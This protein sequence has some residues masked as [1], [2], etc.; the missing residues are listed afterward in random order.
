MAA[1]GKLEVKQI[2]SPIRRQK[3]QAEC[4]KGLG[5]GK[6]NRSRVLEDTPSIRGL[7]VKVSHLVDVKE[8]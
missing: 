8:L 6:L 2:G 5:L 4:L 3:V 7:I 1:K